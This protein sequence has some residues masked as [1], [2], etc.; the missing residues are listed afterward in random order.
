[1]SNEELIRL[2]EGRGFAAAVLDA[3]RIPVNAKFRPFC[4]E[5]RCGQYN[6]NYSCPPT[7]GTPQEM[8][9]KLRAGRMALVLKTEWPIR[10]Y[11]DHEAIRR[12]KSEHN[13]AMLRLNE[14]LEH[15]GLC[16]GG[17]CCNLCSPCRMALGEPCADPKRRFSCMS[18]YCVDVAELAK[19]CG[20]AFSWDP[21][22]LQI[23]S[24]IVLK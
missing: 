21:Q 19:R 2:A 11:E 1:M 22:N 20:M 7:C 14:S 4:A 10:G 23:F 18:A 9:A 12:A 16:A 5:N 15:P 13:G 17:S 3:A 8:E 6:A 24:M